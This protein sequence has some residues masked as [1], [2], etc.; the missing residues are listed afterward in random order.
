[1]RQ[2]KSQSADVRNVAPDRNTLRRIIN[3]L[4]RTTKRR[5]LLK[6]DTKAA[7][8]MRIDV[9]GHRSNT[10]ITNGVIPWLYGSETC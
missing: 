1:M 7:L 10:Q 8:E 3:G 6:F 4:E 9:P 5:E 2:K